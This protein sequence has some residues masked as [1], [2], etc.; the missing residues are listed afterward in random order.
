MLTIYNGRKHFWQWDSGQ[1]LIVE[2]GTICEVHFR[3]P[4]GEDALIVHTYEMDGKSVADVPDILL[5]KSGQVNAWVYLCVGDDCTIQENSFDVWPRQ[6][7]SDYVYTP[8]EKQ[9]YERL[10]Q[11]IDDLEENGVSDEQIE[12]AVTKYL[13]ENPIDTGVNFTTDKTLKLEDGVLSV[14]TAEAVEEDNT[15]PITSAAVHTTVGNIEI[16]LGTI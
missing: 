10:E 9:S 8:A 2:N 4:D 14:N 3:N 5:Q 6:K 13:D 16:L 11:R 1:R 12:K 15:L 7:P